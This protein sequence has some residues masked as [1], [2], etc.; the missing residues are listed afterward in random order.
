MGQGEMCTVS[1]TPDFIDL[2]LALSA[3]SLGSP[4]SRKPLLGAPKKV[5]T[6]PHSMVFER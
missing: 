4:P 6:L 1:S 2:M 5:I 3:Y